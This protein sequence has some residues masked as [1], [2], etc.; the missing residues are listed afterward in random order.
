[1]PQSV[2]ESNLI[3]PQSYSNQWKQIKKD[4]TLK[5]ALKFFP[6]DYPNF[7]L[8]YILDNIED[9]KLKEYAFKIN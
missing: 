6:D 5:A 1:M 8:R 3:E 9:V 4:Y 7:G 2:G